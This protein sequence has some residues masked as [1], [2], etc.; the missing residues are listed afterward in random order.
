MN[1]VLGFPILSL[2]I[3]LPLIGAIPIM[4]FVP[5]QKEELIRWLS[6]ITT[7]VTFIVSLI[8][9]PN[10]DTATHEMQFVERHSWIPSI[11]VQY[12][13]GIDG[14]SFL[15]VLLTTMIT[16][17]AVLSSWHAISER[18]KEFHV[19][20]LLLEVGMLG[21]FM[22]LDFVFFYVFW[23]VMLVP[24]YF[25]I[26]IWG[27]P[28]RLYSAIKFFLYTLL[29]SVF[30]LVAILALFFVYHHYTGEYTFNILKY[31]EF[32]FPF[33]VQW[34]VFLAFFLGF[35][36][37]VPM[38]PFHTW[39]PDA[40]VE[41]PTAGSVILAGI[42]LKM[43]T[44]G[45]VR[46]ALP[47]TPDAAHTFVPFIVTLSIIAIIYAAFICL[48][49]KDMKKLIAYSS[50]SHMGYITLG[51]FTF[52]P[53]GLEG[54]ILQMI[55][56]GLSSAALFLIVGLVYERRHTRM[57]A[58]FGGLAK[59]M[60]IYAVFFAIATMSSIGLPGLNGF[61]GEFLILL[62]VF[63]VS[64]IWA[65]LAAFGI[66]VGAAYA[67]WLYQRTMFGKLENPENIELKDL[68]LRE[69]WT[70]IPLIIMMF[71]IGLYP[72]PFLDT[73]HASV[74][75]IVQRVN[76]GYTPA[77]ESFRIESGS[78]PTADPTHAGRANTNEPAGHG[79]TAHHGGH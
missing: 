23:E 79:D 13:L 24:M 60:P 14:I 17:I 37:K 50:V 8:L 62:G 44:Y 48:A 73:M 26:G 71:W 72:K 5:K 11:G 78:V 63:K 36:V 59:V 66:V 38:F 16:F 76:P 18:L 10:F 55:N 1:N 69:K 15:L 33:N 28:R 57:I 27:G 3:F 43:G 21:A 32:N 41:A 51:T 12:F 74:N 39:L 49:Q 52:N 2:I 54:A 47:I 29:G 56:H 65:F 22:A 20:V 9:I 64:Y 68:N 4:L 19:C 46:F 77:L 6:A 61:I 35:A 31:M 67:L 53:Q 45:F 40:H 70:L 25:I 42:L 34:W 58:D 7:F 30:M 75:N